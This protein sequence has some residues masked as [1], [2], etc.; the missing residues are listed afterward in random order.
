MPADGLLTERRGAVTLLTINRPDV[1]NCID[2][3]TA[4]ALTRA[5]EAFASDPEARVL[6]VTG[7]G[8]EA[9]CA[10]ADLRDIE[11]LMLRQDRDRTA[12][13][14]FSGLEPGKPRIAAVEGYCV[15]GGI[16]LAC[17][18]DFRVAG[19]GAVFGALNRR[20]GVPWVD[21]GTQR[22]PRIVGQGN[23]LYLLESG[24]RI[25]ARRAHEMGLV[26]EVTAR[27][28]ALARA[29]ELAERIAG[30]PQRSL[31]SDRRSALEAWGRSLDEGRALEAELGSEAAGDPEMIDGARGFLER[32]RKR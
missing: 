30:Y 17:W 27:G 19:E 10:G 2:A 4:T 11:G 31:L 25:D 5:I 3:P 16:E 29:V 32:G 15:G 13:L 14:G 6:V 9:F 24:E 28:R 20:V 12:P 22:L 7:A 8:G 21:G 23:A 26:Q 18:C 1:R